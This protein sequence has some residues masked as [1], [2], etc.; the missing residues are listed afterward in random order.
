MTVYG[1]WQLQSYTLTINHYLENINDTNY[2]FYAKTTS[3]L[4]YGTSI[5]LANYKTTVTNGT[6]HHGTNSSGATV[7]TVTMGTGTTI[8]LYYSRNKYTLTLGKGNY[9]SAVSGGGTYKVGQSVTINATLE[10]S[11]TGYTNSWS[12][13]TGTYTS[14]S[15]PYTFTMPEGNV[16]L[17]ANGTRKANSYTVTFNA[18]GGSVSTASKAVTYTSTYGTLPTPTKTGYTFL[19]WYSSTYKDHPLYYYANTYTDLKNAFGYNETSLYSHWVSNG[20]NEGRRLSEYLSTDTVT[21]AGN[22]TMYAGWVANTYTVTFDLNASGGKEILE[23]KFSFSHYLSGSGASTT[24]TKTGNQD[25]VISLEKGERVEYDYVLSC[26][27]ST[28][29]ARAA[30][31]II[32][33]YTGATMT[34]EDIASISGVTSKSGTYTYKA[35]SPVTLIIT[36]DGNRVSG[37]NAM[38]G[39]AKVYVDSSTAS[40]DT[41]EKTVTYNSQYGALPTPTRTGYTFA[42]WYTAA[43]GGNQVTSDTTVST[44]SNHTLYAHWNKIYTAVGLVTNG[45]SQS[46]AANPY[47]FS[48]TVIKCSPGATATMQMQESFVKSGT[49]NGHSWSQTISYNSYMGSDKTLSNVENITNGV[50]FTMPETDVILYFNYVV[51]SS[52]SN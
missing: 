7:T 21:T 49:N 50:R 44:A 27:S 14:S 4:P 34:V 45:S 22:I 10:T 6:Y 12:G 29:N 39:T 47:G 19:G 25:M 11:A 43:N 23:K 35:E 42:G 20:K 48:G 36:F 9:I 41:S 13:W 17:T 16:T 38:T 15:N 40:S 26:K 51:T 5:T 46:V 2:T 32:N 1:I 52:T 3:T 30:A 31:F 18:N 37:G 8:N 28:G 33:N 24:Y